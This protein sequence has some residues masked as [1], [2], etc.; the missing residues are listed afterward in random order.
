VND[1]VRWVHVRWVGARKRGSS[2]QE[3]AASLRSRR[4]RRCGSRSARLARAFVGRSRE[5]VARS[6]GVEQRACRRADPGARWW[7]R[8]VEAVVVEDAADGGEVLDDGHGLQP[9]FGTCRASERVSGGDPPSP[10]HALRQ[11]SKA[12]RRGLR[13][14]LGLATARG[15]RA[16]RWSRR[17]HR[18]AARA[19][20]WTCRCGRRSGNVA[21]A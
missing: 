18:S 12:R 20:W 16:A 2:W 6:V 17:P 1:G 3:P 19:S 8:V 14:G 5:V 21:S 10:L 15:Y 4:G 11:R 13:N 7:R 9:A